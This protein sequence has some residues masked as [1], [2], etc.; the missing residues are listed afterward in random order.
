MVSVNT[1][2]RN[3]SSW[4]KYKKI[5]QETGLPFQEFDRYHQR[6]FNYAVEALGN[7]LPLPLSEVTYTNSE[8]DY[9]I[10]VMKDGMNDVVAGVRLKCPVEELIMGK[11]KLSPVMTGHR[12]DYFVVPLSIG[13]ETLMEI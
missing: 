3:L 12:V 6:V 2:K 1:L 4:H 5:T 8:F 7:L 11:A 13:E 10:T 9:F